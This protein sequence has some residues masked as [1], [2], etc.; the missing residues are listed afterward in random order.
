MVLGAGPAQIGLLRAAREREL[1]VMACDR[2]PGAP[3]FAYADRRAIVSAEDEEGCDRLAR[4][5]RVDAV[6]APGIDWPVAIAA[7]IAARH[8][9]PHPISPESGVLAVSKQ[10]QRARLAEAGVEQPRFRVAVDEPGARAATAELGFPC[11]VKPP[12]RQGQL[13]VSIV[14]TEADLPEAVAA[15]LEVARAKLC[16]VEEHVVGSEVTVNAFSVDGT[17]HPLTVT[18]RLTA[19]PPAFGVALAHAWPAA[20]GTDEACE[21]A[22][23]AAS[24]LGIV[25]GPTYTQIMLGPDGPRVV[26]LAARLGGGQD[27]ELCRN[28]LGVDLNGLALDAALGDPINLPAAEPTAA[29]CVRFLVAPEGELVETRGLERAA[30]LE[31]VVDVVSF[32]RPGFL[33]GPLR[34]GADRAGFVLARGSSREE[35]LARA[36]AAARLVQFVTADGCV[37]V[38]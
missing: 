9:L 25:D 26:E 6:I 24:A 8:R 15:A 38:T 35:A 28:A 19:G 36:D 37:T 30:A 11:V 13:G 2:D 1:F 16:L 10:R 7:R 20:A 5:E 33:F 14:H 17:F 34:R 18:D 3:G 22:R 12:D 27:A 23:R 21:L 29:A 4:A 31:G 32:R